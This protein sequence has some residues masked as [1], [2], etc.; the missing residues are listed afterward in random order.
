MGYTMTLPIFHAGT[1]ATPK[2]NNVNR[3][4]TIHYRNEST[5]Q[6]MKNKIHSFLAASIYLLGASSADAHLTYTG[7]DFGT[8]P[9]NGSEAPVAIAIPNLSSNFGWAD[10]TDADFGDSHR[11]RAFRFKLT[12]P[13]VVNL[14]VQG[15][16]VGGAS[17]LQYP[18][19]S[20]Y[21][22]LAHVAPAAAAHDGSIITAT[23]LGTLGGTQPKEGALV[24][25]GNWKIGNEDVFNT[26]GDPMSGVAIPASLSSLTYIG[27]AADGTAANYGS[28]PGIHGDGVADG[29]VTGTVTLPAGDYTVIVGGA[30]Y[31][32]SVGAVGP[33][34]NYGVT[35]T[36]TVSQAPDAIVKNGSSSAVTGAIYS[37]LYPPA[38][39]GQGTLAFRAGIKV[40]R[41]SSSIIARRTI[42]VAAVAQSGTN[43]ADTDANWRSFG[44]P[45]INEAGEVAF[46]GLLLKGTGNAVTTN[47]LGLWSDLGGALKLALREG[48]AAPGA[49][50]GQLF[51]S[52]S[53]FNLQEGVLFVG[54]ATSN[55]TVKSSGVW[56]WDGSALSK[57]VVPGDSLTL[58]DGTSHVVKTVS[59]SASSG[60]GNATS[61]LVG[62][63]S[64]LALLVTF[65]DGRAELVTFR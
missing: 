6:S 31:A 39:N 5:Y 16:V 52:I 45:V 40:G 17:A 47:D 55:G 9:G 61:R 49:A 59:K 13:A 62:S 57:I 32:A 35:V 41:V 34:T 48:A 18:A 53:W 36:L 1:C 33:F 37:S 15:S 50:S 25:L 7:K 56:K 46:S 20:I 43:A 10:G 44:D 26:P 42:R 58:L 3:N 4:T 12:S 54:A 29:D 65:T 51:T 63:D 38:I 22:G 24:S 30:D 27:H 60:N 19:F 21:S 2:T 8:L 11:T 23:Y 28:V 14:R 64:T